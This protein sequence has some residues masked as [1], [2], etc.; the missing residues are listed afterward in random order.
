MNP[1]R[2]EQFEFAFDATAHAEPYEIK[3][4]TVPGWPTDHKV[5]DFVCI[6]PANGSG[7][8]WLVEAK[9]YR[10]ITNPPKPANLKNLAETMECKARHSLVGL[11]AISLLAGHRL[12]GHAATAHATPTKR[13]VLHLEPHPPNGPDIGL[14]PARFSM[15]VH[16]K[17]KSLVYDID[18]NPLVLDIAR[19]PA[20]SVP[21]T[22]T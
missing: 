9:D 2:V 18:P 11:Q 21:W 14:F 15:L 3:G 1:I 12:A 16:Q 20:A 4:K 13:V 17:L 5:V 10:V 7:S 8:T 22:V 19:T 6:D